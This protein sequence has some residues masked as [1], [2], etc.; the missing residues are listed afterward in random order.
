MPAYPK[1]RVAC[2]GLV[3]MCAIAG[4]CANLVVHKVPLSERAANCDRE[5][6]FRYYLNRPYVVVKK[7]IVIAE[8]RS[9]VRADLLAGTEAAQ[10]PGSK[11]NLG[12]AA[13]DQVMLTFL[14]GPR[15]GRKVRLADLR[16]ETPGAGEVRAMSSAEIQKISGVL[17]TEN[18]ASE[19]DQTIGARDTV[20]GGNAP[21]GGNNGSSSTG[22]SAELQ[23]PTLVT[24][25]HTP[26][27]TGDISILYLPDL[28]EQY[29]I[30]SHNCL[31]K[32]AF[33]LAIR[34]GSELVEVQGE[35]DSTA[36]P[37]AIL[38]QV[39]NAIAA[40][41]GASKQ[42]SQQQ[43]AGGGGPAGA[44]KETQANLDIQ[45]QLVWYL[46]ERT[47]IKP[48]VYRLN[49]PWECEHDVQ[50]QSVGCGLL[51]KLGLPTVVDVDFKPAAT[52]K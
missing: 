13:P 29:V 36:V 40:A 44:G 32:S 19:D 21:V 20:S 37:I 35:H 2:V 51:A 34:Y 22:G 33:G 27:L 4:G 23:E 49:K 47:S 10:K 18:D 43:Q 15:E 48:G 8:N 41:V 52:I 3:T 31:A 1:P 26:P 46:I 30:K 45:G 38:T 7:P 12:A 16:V 50:C 14:S 17:T 9:L 6:G 42:A 5:E 28:D 24:V 11:P 39:Q 25:Q